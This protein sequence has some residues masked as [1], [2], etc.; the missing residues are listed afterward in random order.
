MWN[1][2]AQAKAELWTYGT[3]MMNELMDHTGY[4]AKICE[5]PGQLSAVCVYLK[6]FPKYH[7][8]FTHHSKE[9]NIQP[10]TQ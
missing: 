3:V 5:N 10:N 8:A 7:F 1:T 2:V 9:I 4:Y 6:V